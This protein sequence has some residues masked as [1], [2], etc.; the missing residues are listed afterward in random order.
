MIQ[1]SALL[2]W[3][4]PGWS[5]DHAARVVTEHRQLRPEDG[6]AENEEAA[7]RDE[8]YTLMRA[9]MEA[10]GLPT[11][12]RKESAKMMPHE[13]T[14]KAVGMDAALNNVVGELHL[15]ML[16]NARKGLFA[17]V[18]W[19]GVSVHPDGA[20]VLYDDLTPL[21]ERLAEL[22]ESAGPDGD[23]W[24]L[25]A[26]VVK[27]LELGE[28]ATEDARKR[29]AEDGAQGCAEK[30]IAA[31]ATHTSK[32]AGV[33]FRVALQRVRARAAK[34][35]EEAAHR[36]V[37]VVRPVAAGLLAMSPQQ[38]L[39]GIEGPAPVATVDG[40][41]FGRID[42]DVAEHVHLLS[43]VPGLRLITW[44]ARQ[45]HRNVTSRAVDPRLVQ[46]DGGAA[47]L[48]EL[49]GGAKDTPWLDILRAGAGFRFVHGGRE[50]SA[51]WGLEQPEHPAD[52]RRKPIQ[53][54]ILTPLLPGFVHGITDREARRLVPVLDFEPPVGRLDAS[55]HAAVWRAANG[56]VVHMVDRAAA[57]EVE[58]HGG[59]LMDGQ[60]WRRIASTADVPWNDVDRMLGAWLDGD[61]DKAPP[62]IVREGNAIRLADPHAPQWAFIVKGGALRVR[63]RAS[64]KAAAKSRQSDEVGARRSKR[65]R[66]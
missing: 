42:A 25:D 66:K 10:C 24:W 27:V 57:G 35:L 53:I 43:S 54:V 65:D 63:S 1:Q 61:N 11:P 31:P 7:V 4:D 5:L 3:F 8:V 52:R 18:R 30:Y 17:N 56:L 59:V 19:A 45:G 50:F 39:R 58:E 2:S 15:R 55:K 47:D 12:A 9:V 28:K 21:A 13:S 36:G 29:W 26:A 44:L 46:F 37:A 38:T 20:S 40:R 48:R 23:M 62:L 34:A 64:G 16:D 51:L 6:P 60:R 14:V 33:V 32:A 41:V 22:A 49:F